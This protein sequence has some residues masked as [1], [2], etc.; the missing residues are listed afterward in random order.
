VF[1]KTIEFEGLD[2]QPR[3]KDFYFHLSGAEF[4][5][6]A[7]N[8]DEMT[9][10]LQRI[11]AEKDMAAILMEFREI[12]KK[13]CGVRSEDGERFVKTPEAQREL[14]DSPAYDE[15]L[16]EL[17]TKPDAAVDFINQLIPQKMRDE[18]LAKVNQN[19]ESMGRIVDASN[20][21]VDAYLPEDNRPAWLREGRAPTQDEIKNASLEDLRLAFRH[22]GK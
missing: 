8:G 1:K 22:S 14:L 15:L 20:K 2:G 3:T 21:V 9:A 19:S 11:V 10:R 7:A 5:E 17:C 13:A 18:L 6:M 12:I 16:L 4:L